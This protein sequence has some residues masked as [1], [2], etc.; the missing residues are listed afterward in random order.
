MDKETIKK[1]KLLEG[2]LKD[3]KAHLGITDEDSDLD[4]LNEDDT[5]EEPMVHEVGRGR[6]KRTV[7]TLGKAAKGEEEEMAG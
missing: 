3:L 1:I 2:Q 5:V 7:P 4:E 6:K